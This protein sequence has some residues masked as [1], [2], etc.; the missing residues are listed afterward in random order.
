MKLQRVAN[1]KTQDNAT[2]H[3]LRQQTSYPWK[4]MKH[5]LLAVSIYLHACSFV[6]NWKG[7]IEVRELLQD[8]IRDSDLCL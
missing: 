3:I 8:A 4:K 6:K 1:Q 2:R 7:V 5:E